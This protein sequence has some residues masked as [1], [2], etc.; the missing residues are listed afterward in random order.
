[1]VWAFPADSTTFNSILQIESVD[2]LVQALVFPSLNRYDLETGQPIPYL[3]SWEISEDGLTYT[4]S[5]DEAAVWSDGT[6][7]T[8]TDVA[9]TLNAMASE[10]V[11][12]FRAI[13]GLQGINIV[14]DKHFEIVLAAPT[15]GLFSQIGVPIMPAHKF[16]ADYSDFMTSEFN[17]NP[18]VSGGPYKLVER[19][20]DEFLRFEANDT[21][22]LGKPNIDQMLLQ[23]IVD[24]QVAIQSVQS[25]ESDFVTGLSSETVAPFVDNPAFTVHPMELNGW[26]IMLFNHADPAQP[27]PARDEAGALI[28]QPP[29]PILGDARVRQAL[30]MGWDHED[31]VFLTGAGAR[32]LVGP[33]APILADAYNNDLTLYPYDSEAAAAL[34]DEAGW[35]LNGDV[36]EKDG[37]PLALELAYLAQFEDIAAVVADYWTDLGVEVTLTTGEQG[38]MIGEKLGPQAFDVFM[39]QATWN[40]PTPDVLLNFLWSGANDFGTNFGSFVNEEFDG[41]LAELATAD[42]A[43]EARKPLYDRAQEIMHDG[44][45]TDFVSTVV[46]YNVT[47]ARIGGISFTA[48]G[49][50]PTWTWTI[51]E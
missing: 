16:A 49:F 14:D 40:E 23:V 45:V 13:A 44:A 39:I 25:G 10:N 47:S 7:I 27:S 30:I 12:T 17:T 15:C 41:L 42:C 3:A 43:P 21:F 38:A 33:V 18:D 35:V 50:T 1:M 11:E 24:P 2:S 4:F 26:R 28:E 20:V 19:A 8:S 22:F 6:P 36:R 32:R 48:W 51:N 31:G 46:N 9:F 5:I 29:H 34:L 37:V